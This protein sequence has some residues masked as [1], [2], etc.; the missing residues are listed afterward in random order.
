MTTERAHDLSIFLTLSYKALTAVGIVWNVVVTSMNQVHVAWFAAATL[1]LAGGLSHAQSAGPASV[2]DQ[3]TDDRSTETADFIA[4]LESAFLSAA[5]TDFE[6]IQEFKDLPEEVD[7]AFNLIKGPYG[8][9][10]WGDRFEITDVAQGLPDVRHVISWVST[11]LSVTLY[12]AQ[13]GQLLMTLTDRGDNACT[14]W[15]GQQ[16]EPLL[17]LYWVQAQFRPENSHVTSLQPQCSYRS[18]SE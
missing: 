4:T 6:S 5:V 7:S 13:R 9:A 15:L 17:T 14:Y 3:Q 1:I 2:A 16:I 12:Q 8:I 10:E 11:N 18:L